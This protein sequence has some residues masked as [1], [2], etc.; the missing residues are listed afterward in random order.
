[1]AVAMPC[2][3][4]SAVDDDPTGIDPGH[5]GGPTETNAQRAEKVACVEMK[6]DGLR[7]RF[8]VEVCSAPSTLRCKE[9]MVSGLGSVAECCNLKA[10]SSRDPTS[11]SSSVSAS[12]T[13]RP[14]AFSSGSCSKLLNAG[15]NSDSPVPFDIIPWTQNGI[16]SI[17]V[18]NTGPGESGVLSGGAKNCVGSVS[19]AVPGNTF[20]RMNRLENFK[21]RIRKGAADMGSR[22][23]P[24]IARHPQASSLPTSPE[25]PAPTAALAGSNPV[26]SLLAATAAAASEIAN[27]CAS[28]PNRSRTPPSVS[29][30]GC[31]SRK[32]SPSITR[33]RP[34]SP[35]GGGSGRRPPSPGALDP[36]VMEAVKRRVRRVQKARLYL[37][38]QPGPNSFLVGGD[39]PEHK[40][41]VVIGPQSCSCGRGPHCLHLLFVMLR[42]F[43]VP[44]NDTRIYA[45]E[46]KNFE[47]ESLFRHYQQRRNSRVSGMPEEI[48]KDSSLTP[49][50]V[51]S[52]PSPLTEGSS[53]SVVDS[54]S[55]N[56]NAEEEEVCPICLLEMVDGESLVVCTSGCR[57]KL[58]LHCMAIWAAECTQQG[59]YVLCPLCRQPWCDEASAFKSFPSMQNIQS[60]GYKHVPGTLP[61]FKNVQPPLPMSFQPL[62]GPGPGPGSPKNQPKGK[63]LLSCGSPSGA[64]VKVMKKPQCLPLTKA[65]HLGALSPTEWKQ[66]HVTYSPTSSEISLP[67]SGIIPPEQIGTAAEW[68]KVF[69]LALVSCLYSRDWKD[70]EMA[71]RKLVNEVISVYQSGSEERQQ[72]V[73]WCCAKILAMVIADPVFKVYLG[74]LRCFRVLVNNAACQ[75]WSQS[76]EFQELIRP[77][78]KT[79]LKKCADRNRRTSHLSAEVLVELARG[80]SGEQS[81]EPL[82]W[83][84]DGLEIILS[85]VLE[86]FTVESVS[87]QWLAGRLLM[88]N[89][90]LQV[91]PE[92]FCLRYV[93]LYANESGYKLNNFNR[94]L[95][96]IEFSFKA[97]QSSHSTVSK[98]ARH[99]FVVSSSMTTAER[100]MLNQILEMIS[101]LDISLQSRL[102]KRLQ[103]AIDSQSQTPNCSQK[104]CKPARGTQMNV[105]SNKI[106][107]QGSSAVSSL[108]SSSPPVR[109]K[110]LPL[111]SVVKVRKATRHQQVPNSHQSP[112]PSS[113]RWINS[114]SKL[115]SLFSRNKKVEDILPTKPELNGTCD[116]GCDHGLVDSP[117]TPTHDCFCHSPVEDENI[118]FFSRVMGC[119]P[120]SPNDRPLCDKVGPVTPNEG[121]RPQE[122]EQRIPEYRGTESETLVRPGGFSI[123]TRYMG[124]IVK[125]T[126]YLED[127]HWKRGPLLGTGA[128][129]TCYQARDV[130]TGTLMAVKQVPYCRNSEEEQTCVEAGIRKEILTM[131]KLCHPNVLTILGATRQGSHFNIFVEWMA[132]GSVAGLLDSYGP[133]NQYVIT[134]YTKQVLEGLNYLHE[135]HILHRDLKGANLLVD[136][137]GKHLRIGDFGAAARLESQATISGEF[138]GQLL[139]TI[140]FMAPEV[141][142]GEDYGRSCDIWSVGCCMIEM[143]T[144]KAPWK[145]NRVSNHL[146]LMYKIASSKDPP[147]V[148]DNLGA[149][150]KDLALKCLQVKSDLR[151][152]AKELLSHHCF[153]ILGS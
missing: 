57:N 44:E 110:D 147:F 2:P 1:M 64:L 37:L 4:R 100:G 114:G 151:P 118:S 112:S 105:A 121:E 74:C 66:N 6:T 78:I 24:M 20:V 52:S 28:P 101:E 32:R 143:A 104:K 58:H 41:R 124:E 14:R 139:G 30:E 141:L 130:E 116:S 88:L 69:G 142:R 38:Q 50:N 109:P 136:S 70:R 27:K 102:K 15:T 133:F 87:W 148:P 16:D 152:S 120:N 13:M 99:V 153:K 61:I 59:E 7:S 91:F 134:E 17:S 53:R 31:H 80:P 128:Y 71:L 22:R 12:R 106:E 107:M 113:K 108:R 125:L 46:L 123:Q 146:A 92:E 29:G 51:D 49:S 129:S 132:G 79:L 95:S 83:S 25:T 115:S 56:K 55:D 47:V 96:V 9:T 34:S 84:L 86:P 5:E 18:L 76:E 67:C 77:V 127:V 82:S 40:Y 122:N 26:T 73:S 93:P 135:N 10:S 72:K 63:T 19:S 54:A 98:L 144:S 45:K 137:T 103:L 60:N 119:V 150:T 48:H 36:S 145:E 62:P 138:Q 131:S 11:L 8:Y 117:S 21:L 89:T 94:L 43:Q 81:S 126:T 39:S 35:G 68:I 3:D 75:N 140:A 85:C 111:E 23:G 97:L 65:E 149:A 90:L 42:V 33:S